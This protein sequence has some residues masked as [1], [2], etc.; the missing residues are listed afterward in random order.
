MKLSATTLVEAR[1]HWAKAVGRAF[2]RSYD[3]AS[4][5]TERFSQIERISF[6]PRNSLLAGCRERLVAFLPRDAK[7][8]STALS[9]SGHF[10]YGIEDEITY[11]RQVID[12]YFHGNSF[13]VVLLTG[14]ELDFIHADTNVNKILYYIVTVLVR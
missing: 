5:H 2:N 9:A 1:E 6:G 10:L 12:L 13:R 11:L 8:S 7:Y 3:S 14:L 4:D